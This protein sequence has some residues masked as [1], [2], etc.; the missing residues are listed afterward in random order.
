M[1]YFLCV[2][3]NKQ[4]DKI[5]VSY[6]MI[7]ISDIKLSSGSQ[8]KIPVQLGGD[9]GLWQTLTVQ[10]R[11]MVVADHAGLQVTVL[12]TPILNKGLIPSLH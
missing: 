10:V 6:I 5:N 9:S 12:E 1:K 4:C 8:R 7:Q 3:L 11:C 2:N